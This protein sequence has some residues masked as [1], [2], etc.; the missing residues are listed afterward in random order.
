MNR[1]H[2]ASLFVALVAAAFIYGTMWTKDRLTAMQK[3]EA[4]A[5]AK[6][7]KAAADLTRELGEL[8]ALRLRSEPLIRFLDA[9]EPY[10]AAMNTPQSAELGIS[11]SIKE[12]GIITLAQR[13]EPVALKGEK[14]IPRVM[15]AN[16]T[17]EDD[18]VR[19]LNWLGK[20][21]SQIPTLRIS[22]LR[23]SK[24]QRVNDIKQ[25]IVLDIPLA[26]PAK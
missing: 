18:Y 15:R 20:I 14:T 16:L 19:A 9:W 21:E 11:L 6:S 25:E 24:G 7:E 3:S 2:L 5:R 1:K 4:S 13:Y 17:I 8:S 26:N 23:V 22:N 12:D 10:F